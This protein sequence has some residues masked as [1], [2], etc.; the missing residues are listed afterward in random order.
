[1]AMHNISIN[2][3]QNHY[4]WLDGQVGI[5][6]APNRSEALRRFIQS[7]IKNVNFYPERKKNKN[8]AS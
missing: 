6:M 5:G 7:E 4:D 1:M 3:S 8:G 2:L